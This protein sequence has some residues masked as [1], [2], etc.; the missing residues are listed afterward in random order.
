MIF[1]KMP[2]INRITAIYFITLFFLYRFVSLP[3]IFFII[4]IFCYVLIPAYG[5]FNICSNF[6]VNTLCSIAEKNAVCLSFNLDKPEVNPTELLDCMDDYNVKGIFF[7]SGHYVKANP[8]W[9][10]L[11]HERGHAF[12]NHYFYNSRNFGFDRTSVL[13]SNLKETSKL[14]SGITGEMVIYF[15]PPF[16]ITNPFVKKAIK[17]LELNV[18][19]WQIK[20][21]R[22]KLGEDS[23]TKK[24]IRKLRGG[25]IILVDLPDYVDIERIRFVIEEIKHRDLIFRLLV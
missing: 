12:G 20:F 25:E 15:R 16:G 8:E 21:T 22:K 5:S 9:V 1:L 7:V 24:I 4:A 3:D 6:Y 11:V 17:K 2:K 10:K 19:G 23:S 14:I 13:I 18:I